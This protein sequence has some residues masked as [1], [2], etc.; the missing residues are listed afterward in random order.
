MDCHAIFFLHRLNLVPNDYIVLDRT[1]SL[2]RISGDLPK[3]LQKLSVCEKILSPRKSDEKCT[4]I[5][6]AVANG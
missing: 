5:D 4:V 6:G 3:N 1:H 2:H